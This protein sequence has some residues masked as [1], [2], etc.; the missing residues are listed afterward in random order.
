ME[1]VIKHKLHIRNP[2]S[3]SYCY[4]ETAYMQI[5]RG[6]WFFSRGR[7]YDLLILI[8]LPG[9]INTRNLLDV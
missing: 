6:E 2:V 7:V 1:Q 5:E 8:H 4:D 3:V 9:I